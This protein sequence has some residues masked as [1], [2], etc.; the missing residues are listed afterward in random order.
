MVSDYFLGFTAHAHTKNGLETD[1]NKEMELRRRNSPEE[2]QTLTEAVLDKLQKDISNGGYDLKDVKLL[3][4]YLSY[5][6]E[7][8]EKDRLIC[9]RILSA[10]E[11]RFGEHTATNQL[12]LIGHTTAGEIENED[13]QLKE[14]S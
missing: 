12:R 3:V 1:Q 8:E 9:E 11:K 2:A 7:P 4:L 14:V 5:R 6:G 10:I 13:L